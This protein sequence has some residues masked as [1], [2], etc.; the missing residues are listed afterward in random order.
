MTHH[1]T[2]GTVTYC[3]MYSHWWFCL[4]L[5]ENSFDAVMSNSTIVYCWDKVVKLF[6]SPTR[7]PFKER[8]QRV[9]FLIVGTQSSARAFS[10]PV[11]YLIVQ[12]YSWRSSFQRLTLILVVPV[13]LRIIRSGLFYD[14]FSFSNQLTAF[15][16]ADLAW[17]LWNNS[18]FNISMM[19][20]IGHAGVAQAL[21]ART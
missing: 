16:S 19:L 3:L 14:C 4:L 20:G 5:G 15:F 6:L 1:L 9:S 13:S 18:W 17:N 11:M 7:L 10:S 8:V 21:S 2:A 12:S